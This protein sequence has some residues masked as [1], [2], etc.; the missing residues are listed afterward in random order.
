[1]IELSQAGAAILLGLAGAGHCLGMCGA[2]TSALSLG[3][4]T[5]PV[6]LMLFQ[7]GRISGYALLGAAAAAAVAT[8]SG[9]IASPYAALSVRVIAGLL[10]VGMGLYIGEWWRG[11][12]VLERA[13]S[14]L[15]AP[16]Q[17]RLPALLPLRGPVQSVA[18]GLCWF[19][20]PCGLIYS[21]IAWSATAASPLN[22]GVLML[23]F[24]IGTLPALTGVHLGAASLAALL[25][26]RKAKR[27]LGMLLIASGIWTIYIAAGHADHAGH[28]GMT[29]GHSEHHSMHH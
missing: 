25:K 21:A 1:V 26:K 18:V 20:M 6:Y 9:G 29:N 8:L 22:A 19:L 13:G 15:F 14:L 16:L 17:R 7:V 23:C 3:G 4:Q 11:M 27:T 5:K 24:G 12:L 28:S 2:L 10:L